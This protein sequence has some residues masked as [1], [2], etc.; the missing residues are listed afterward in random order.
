MAGQAIRPARSI[1]IR[2]GALSAPGLAVWSAAG[3]SLAAAWVH[4]AYTASHW[5]DWWAYGAFFLGMGIFQSLSVPAILRWPRSLWVG[6]ATIAGNLGIVGMY[7]YSRTVEIPM[8]PHEGIVEKAGAIDLATTGAEIAIMALVLTVVGTRS[9]RTIVNVLLVA[10]IGL[11]AL[12]LTN[13][14]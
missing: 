2:P 7:V 10:G 14:L 6:L 8:G 4:F 9:R 1:T 3:L 12:R 11:W 5:R 13:H